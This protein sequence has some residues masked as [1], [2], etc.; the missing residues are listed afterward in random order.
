MNYSDQ[1]LDQYG[2]GPYRVQMLVGQYISS[3][4][5]KLKKTK[6]QKN[7]NCLVQSLQCPILSLYCPMMDGTILGH[8]KENYNQNYYFLVVT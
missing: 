7:T 1:G 8:H 2:T 6:E 3:F 4:E 5:K